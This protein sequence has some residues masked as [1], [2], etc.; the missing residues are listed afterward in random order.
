MRISDWSSDVCSSDLPVWQ[1]LRCATGYYQPRLQ[2]AQCRHAVAGKFNV[3][4]G[5]GSAAQ[6]VSGNDIQSAGQR[7]FKSHRRRAEVEHH[8]L[9]VAIETSDEGEQ[10]FG[11][12]EEADVAPDRKSTR[13]NSVTNA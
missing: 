2:H 1:P 13:L 8:E 7:G 9:G 4:A 10:R 6:A 3:V 11:G 12:V 5:Y